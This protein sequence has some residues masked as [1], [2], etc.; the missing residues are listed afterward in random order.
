MSSV[1]SNKQ[2]SSEHDEID[3]GRIVGEFI[4]HRKLIITITSIFTAISIIYMLFSTPV[5]QADAMIQ[6]EQKQGNALLD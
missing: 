2:P 3:L 4:D 5:Y 6:V 1:T